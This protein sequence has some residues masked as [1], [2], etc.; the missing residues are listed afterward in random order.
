VLVDLYVPV[1]TVPNVVFFRDGHFNLGMPD[2]NAEPDLGQKTSN[3]YVHP[4]PHTAIVKQASFSIARFRCFKSQSETNR[5][6]SV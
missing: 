4:W 1:S 3:S 6:S 5:G 2:L